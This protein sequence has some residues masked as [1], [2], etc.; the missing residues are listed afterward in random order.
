[1]LAPIS[2]PIP[3]A[4]YGPWEQV[5]HNIVEGLVALGH[6]VTLFAAG[7]S[8]SSATVVETT[9]HALGTWP[10]AE[11]N[12]PRAYDPATGLLEGPPDG[13]V[14]EQVHVATCMERA[15]AG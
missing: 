5:A 12:R 11:S 2:W 1:M 6:E 4:G 8:V 10:E 9:P 13:R 3:P 15:A 14:W 7:G